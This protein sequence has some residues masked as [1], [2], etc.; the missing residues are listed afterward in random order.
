MSMGMLSWVR[1]QISTMSEFDSAM[2]PSVQS[3]ESNSSPDASAC[4][5]FH[6][7]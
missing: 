2:Q 6:E 3:L 4:W 7:S 1:I 5:A